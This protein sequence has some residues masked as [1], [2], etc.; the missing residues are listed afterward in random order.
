[1]KVGVAQLE[2]LSCH[3]VSAIVGKAFLHA[4]LTP[5]AAVCRVIRWIVPARQDHF[6]PDIIA[7]GAAASAC[8]KASQWEKTLLVLR[9]A[10]RPRLICC[11]LGAGGAGPHRTHRCC[12]MTAGS[13]TVG[14]S[15]PAAPTDRN[16]ENNLRSD[17]CQ[18]PLLPAGDTT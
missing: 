2:D 5:V 3:P 13:G 7:Y 15:R 10:R 18:E 17:A 14:P 16:R 8:T 4:A 11:W 1:M 9:E 12:S 6:L